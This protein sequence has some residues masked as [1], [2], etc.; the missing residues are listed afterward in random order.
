MRA[1]WDTRMPWST[2]ARLPL[3]SSPI[4]RLPERAVKSRKD[5]QVTSGSRRLEFWPTSVYV[6]KTGGKQCSFTIVAGVRL[7]IPDMAAVWN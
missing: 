7:D 4:L 5:I 2:Y 3:R 6:W 1:R